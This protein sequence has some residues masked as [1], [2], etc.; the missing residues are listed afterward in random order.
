MAETQTAVMQRRLKAALP[1][2]QGY[3]KLQG[4][5]VKI[6]IL[7]RQ[8]WSLALLVVFLCKLMTISVLHFIPPP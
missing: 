8:E 6:V 7:V 2:C 5:V 1:T 3:G 4:F